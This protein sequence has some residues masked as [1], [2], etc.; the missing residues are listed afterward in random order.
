MGKYKA[1]LSPS[2]L[3]EYQY[4]CLE[5]IRAFNKAWNYFAEMTEEEVLHYNKEAVTGHR[6]TWKMGEKI[7]MP[8][9]MLESAFYDFMYNQ[10]PERESEI[11]PG[12][13]LN[14]ADRQAL[15]VLE[16]TYPTTQKDVKQKYKM[17]VKRYHPDTNRGNKTAEEKFKQV[18]AA[19]DHIMNHCKV[20]A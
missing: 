3:N 16:M 13:R 9:E 19:Y 17:L 2:R 5:H 1:P 7:S 18:T 12:M 4:F 15:K 10:K 6:P 14:Q 8:H 20:I 11:D